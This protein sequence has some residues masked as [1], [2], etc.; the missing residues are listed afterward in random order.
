[1]GIGCSFY[2]G[3]WAVWHIPSFAVQ[4]GLYWMMALS[5]GLFMALWPPST[6]NAL[7]HARRFRAA[8]EDCA[9]FV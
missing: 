8:Q 7:F 6:V 4:L 9:H 2:L 1:M 5:G 3:L